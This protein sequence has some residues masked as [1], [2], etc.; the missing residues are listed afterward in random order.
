MKIANPHFAMRKVLD[1]HHA[2]SAELAR[3]S[4]F[5]FNG[6]L[7]IFYGPVPIPSLHRLQAVSIENMPLRLPFGNLK[8][9]TQQQSYDEHGPYKIFCK[10]HCI[11]LG[12]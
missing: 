1:K 2:G 6:L 8:I 3:I 10:P 11:S 12:R 5:D 9:E 4:S 7:K